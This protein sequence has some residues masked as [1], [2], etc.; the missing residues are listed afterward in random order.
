[1]E[2]VN[3]A[4]TTM[5]NEITGIRADH[6]VFKLNMELFVV[7]V[8]SQIFEVL[9]VVYLHFGQISYMKRTQIIYADDL[10]KK[11]VQCQGPLN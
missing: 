4:F 9:Q 5:G 6:L 10:T 7:K 8:N 3:H 11:I 1:M 2:N